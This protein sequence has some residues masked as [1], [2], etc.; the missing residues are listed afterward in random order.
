M[1]RARRRDP[2]W[3]SRSGVHR[4][5]AVVSTTRLLAR[6]ATLA[7]SENDGAGGSKVTPG[8]VLAA[9]YGTSARTAVDEARRGS[10]IRPRRDGLVSS[11]AEAF[12]E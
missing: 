2:R 7:S 8:G 12:E 9:G 10:A 3:H 5:I 11:F 1:A 6:H 4:V